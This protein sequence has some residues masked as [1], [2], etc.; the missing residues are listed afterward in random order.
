VGY[1]MLTAPELPSFAVLPGD[2]E[3]KRI[4]LFSRF[5]SSRTPVL[6]AE[7]E[8]IPG[9]RLGQALMDAAVADARAL[10]RQRL[11]LGTHEGNERA[12]A[13]YLREFV[14]ATD[15]VKHRSPGAACPQA[16]PLRDL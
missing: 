1:A 4:Y 10:G 15:G 2:V 7:G 6:D 9:M 16:R 14:W 8:T 3:L 5:R 13:F 12:I 11:L